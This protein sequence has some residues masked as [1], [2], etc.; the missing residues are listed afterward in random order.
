MESQTAFVELN[1]AA[2]PDMIIKWEAQERSAHAG[3]AADPKAM[4]IYEVQLQKGT[5]PAAI[6]MRCQA[7]MIYMQHHPES[8]RN[9]T[10]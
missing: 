6:M 5:Y 1:D 2:D 3:R 10:S 8:N 9:W 4:D 7:Y